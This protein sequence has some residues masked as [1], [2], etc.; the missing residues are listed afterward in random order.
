LGET[1]ADI[2]RKEEINNFTHELVTKKRSNHFKGRFI[3]R[4]DKRENKEFFNMMNNVGEDNV[5]NFNNQNLRM[6]PGMGVKTNWEKKI[7]VF[8]LNSSRILHE[9]NKYVFLAS[10]AER[11]I[12]LDLKLSDILGFV[13]IKKLFKKVCYLRY[14]LQNKVW[15][16]PN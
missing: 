11:A 13:L 5:E 10:V 14:I 1:P 15:E 3:T 8:K 16:T 9:R 12:S 2:D 4:K 7:R 6:K